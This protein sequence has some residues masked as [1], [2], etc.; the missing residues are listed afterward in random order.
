MPAPSRLV[1]DSSTDTDCAHAAGVACIV[2]RGGYGA[3]LPAVPG[4][5]CWLSLVNAQEPS[6]ARHRRAIEGS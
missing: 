2:F 5:D 4:F 1:G 3:P 6:H